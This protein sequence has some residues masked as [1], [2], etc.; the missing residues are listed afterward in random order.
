MT[1]VGLSR[2]SCM[3]GSAPVPCTGMGRWPSQLPVQGIRSCQ[4][5]AEPQCPWGRVVVESSGPGQCRSQGSVAVVGVH[6]DAG[7]AQIET[8]ILVDCGS[9]LHAHQELT[10]GSL[11][12]V[13]WP[14]LLYL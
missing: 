5:R 9:N 11:G 3:G 6:V 1:G 7:V 10:A 14:V 4:Y 2:E 13:V 8:S 12:P